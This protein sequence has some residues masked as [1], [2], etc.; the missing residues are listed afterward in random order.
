MRDLKVGSFYWLIL[1]GQKTIGKFGGKYFDII[2]SPAYLPSE[3][4]SIG[5]EIEEYCNDGK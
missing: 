4:D 3:F 5:D 2:G 1:K